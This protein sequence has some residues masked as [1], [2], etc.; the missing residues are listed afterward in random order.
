MMRNGEVSSYSKIPVNSFLTNQLSKESENY[1]INPR[2]ERESSRTLQCCRE[3]K[4]S[5]RLAATGPAGGGRLPPREPL[6]SGR[7]APPSPFSPS[8]TSL[9]R[10]LCQPQSSM[11]ITTGKNVCEETLQH[12][13]V[14]HDPK[15]KQK[16]VF[17]LVISEL[18]GAFVLVGY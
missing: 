1:K 6:D 18:S 11:K 17:T 5:T 9:T 15:L 10:L 16:K 14:L 13:K 7:V 12:F 4:E 2:R 3:W 8:R